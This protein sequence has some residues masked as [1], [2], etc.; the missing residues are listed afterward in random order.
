[1]NKLEGNPFLNWKKIQVMY[2]GVLYELQAKAFDCNISQ[3]GVGYHLRF[4]DTSISMALIDNKWVRLDQEN[5]F[6]EVAGKIINKRVHD[7]WQQ[8]HNDR[9]R[10]EKE[11]KKS[12]NGSWGN[13]LKEEIK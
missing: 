12:D 10:A 2:K 6:V 9:I 8:F 11:N 3:E 13:A 5:Q 1:M 7:A 4:K